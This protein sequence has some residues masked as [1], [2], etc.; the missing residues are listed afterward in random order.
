M[1]CTFCA[2][3]DTTEV[4]PQS[5]QTEINIRLKNLTATTLQSTSLRFV[6]Q[7][8]NTPYTDYGQLA[9]DET[10]DY[11]IFN[12]AGACGIDFLSAVADTING[13][14]FNSSCECICPLSP[15]NYTASL[16]YLVQGNVAFFDVSINED[17]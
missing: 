14:N 5:I 6:E 11:R 8:S 3:E 15:G 13:P 16:S 9:P 4:E 2:C 1:V 12:E 10:T 17:N 7:G